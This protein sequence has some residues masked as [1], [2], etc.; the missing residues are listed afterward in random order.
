MSSK[1]PPRLE[2]AGRLHF[3]SWE[4]AVSAAGL[5][6]DAIRQPRTYNSQW[7]SLVYGRVHRRVSQTG[8]DRQGSDHDK[9]QAF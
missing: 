2:Y 6:Y 1:V 9:R 5:D 7:L 3:G 8:A 4:A